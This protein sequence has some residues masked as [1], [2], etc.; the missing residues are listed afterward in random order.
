MTLLDFR[1]HLELLKGGIKPVSPRTVASGGRRR[2]IENTGAQRPT[3]L[4][5]FRRGAIGEAPRVAGIV[6]RACIDQRPVQKIYLGIVRVS[7]G[8]EN[9][10]GAK[11]S[12]RQYE[13]VRVARTGKLIDVGIDLLDLAAEIDGLTKKGALNPCIGIRRA[14]LVGFA[15]QKAG[16]AVGVAET[17]ALIDLGIGPELGALPELHPGKERGVEC[18]ASLPGAA[19]TVLA[20]KRRA[21][22]RIALIDERRLAVQADDVPKRSKWKWRN[23]DLGRYITP[24]IIIQPEPKLLQREIRTDMLRREWEVHR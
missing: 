2:E 20:L 21:K 19:Q 14:K 16:G 10:V 4:I 17:E 6:K 5:P 22:R 1:Q 15:A 23:R 18:L 13:P 11:P 8:V 9:V 7:V 12:H 24:K 3:A